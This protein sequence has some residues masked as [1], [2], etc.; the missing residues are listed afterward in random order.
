MPQYVTTITGEGT[1]DGGASLP[2][3][4]YGFTNETWKGTVAFEGLAADDAT[5]DFRFELYG[6]AGSKIKLTNCSINYLKNN[7]AT[8]PGTLVLDGDGAFRTGNGYSAYYNKF[9]ALEGSGSM[10]FTGAPQQAYVFGTATNFT[11]SITVGSGTDTGA[12]GNQT[13]GRRIVFGDITPTDDNPSREFQSAAIMLQKGVEASIGASATWTAHNGVN[14]AGALQVKGANAAISCGDNPTMGLVLA[15]GAA[16]RFDAADAKLAFGKNLLFASGTVEV[17]FA[18]GVT[19][20]DGATL[21][22]WP[23]AST[24]NG[25]FRLVGTAT[26]DYEIATNATGLVV[27]AKPNDRIDLS[28]YSY[29]TQNDIPIEWLEKG[30]FTYIGDEPDWDEVCEYMS[31]S[32]GNGYA[33]LQNFLLGYDAEPGV[34]RK[35]SAS[36]GFDAEG[37]VVITT[38]EGT[39]PNVQGLVKKLYMRGSLLDPWTVKT[40]PL[41]PGEKSATVE[42]SGEAGFYKVEI[43]LE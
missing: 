7:N 25:R 3:A 24:V 39:V 27:K 20:A 32:A 43:T 28:G 31:S 40:L 30:D 5:K 36:L 33:H 14:I 37:N 18:D 9:G 42:K 1:L 41:N 11:G 2:D 13:R 8:F 35:F 17:A 26:N 23:N 21:V 29:L 19:P 16:L 4:S 12:S 10:S 15:D 22:A 6:N 34:S 38:T